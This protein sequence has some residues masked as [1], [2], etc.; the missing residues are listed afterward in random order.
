MAVTNS[1]QDT[2]WA[3]ASSFEA[4]ISV[5]LQT[6]TSGWPG[7]LRGV[8]AGF[9]E[10]REVGCEHLGARGVFIGGTTTAGLREP[11]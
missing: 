3:H 2:N 11:L 8:R 6:T 4:F 1:A 10:G 5:P 9:K 7:L